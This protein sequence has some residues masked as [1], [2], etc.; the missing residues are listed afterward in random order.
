M[1]DFGMD[2]NMSASQESL[3]GDEFDFDYEKV[4]IYILN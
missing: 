4:R 1:D 2:S 3:V